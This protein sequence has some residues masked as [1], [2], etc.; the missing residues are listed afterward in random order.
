MWGCSNTAMASTARQASQEE[1]TNTVVAN[2]CH[3]KAHDCCTKSA[4]AK[5]S[6]VNSQSPMLSV[7]TFVPAGMM[8]DCPLAVNALAAI[9]KASGDSP[10]PHQIPRAE[11]P[12]LENKPSPAETRSFPIKFLNSGPTNLRCCVLQI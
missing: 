2:S 4:H 1:G 12:T 6:N 7:L 3:A 5:R 10:D 8:N 9:T 11:L